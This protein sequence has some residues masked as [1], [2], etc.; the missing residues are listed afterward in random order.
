MTTIC[1]FADQAG[2]PFARLR[3]GRTWSSSPWMTSIGTSVLGRSSRKSVV[4]VLM[5]AG[6]CLADGEQDP[7]VACGRQGPGEGQLLAYATS[8]WLRV[9]RCRGPEQ[10]G[11]NLDLVCTLIDERAF[12][13]RTLRP[14]C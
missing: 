2:Q 11:M 3:S 8:A 5:R 7:A 1:T 10:P 12:L 4:Q 13:I 9:K 14:I 6:R